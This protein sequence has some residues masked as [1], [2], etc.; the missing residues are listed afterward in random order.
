ME[1]TIIPKGSGKFEINDPKGRKIYSVTKKRKLMGNHITTLHDA[2]N[3]A[4]Y[5][6]VRTAAGKRPSFQIIFNDA[7][8]L[9]V[10]CKSLYVDPSI[11]FE[12]QGGKYE[13]KGKTS[14]NLELRTQGQLIGG[15]VTE[16]QSNGMPKYQLTIEDKFYDDFIPLFAVAVDKCFSTANK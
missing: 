3:Y 14:K 4:L 8:F 10:Q 12:G 11:L 6:M 2:S 9:N 16:E 1:L 7:V 5:T 15:I 13:L